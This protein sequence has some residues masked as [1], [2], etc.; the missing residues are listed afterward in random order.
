MTTWRFQHAA[1]LLRIGAVISHP[2]EGVWGLACDPLN[3]DAVQ[4]ILRMKRRSPEQG[5][6]LVAHDFEVIR[7]YLQPLEPVVFDRVM[8]TWPGPVTWLLPVAPWVPAWITGGR[9]TLAVR[10]SA[11]P[12]TAKLCAAFGDAMVTTS[13]NRSGKPAA[14]TSTAVR[15]HFADSLDMLISGRLQTPGRCSEIRDGHSGKLLRA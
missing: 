13:A 15:A 12:V 1:H 4:R 8:A 11:H 2:T 10:I 6:I 9:S 14:L 3:P 7:P 5:L